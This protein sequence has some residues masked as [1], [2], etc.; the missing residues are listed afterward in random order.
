M[1]ILHFSGY[2]L[3]KLFQKPATKMYP[4]RKREFFERT[5]G[6]IG[7]D[8]DAC[9]FCGMCGRKCPTGAIGVDRN[10]KT[11]D[12]ERLQCIQCSCCVEVCP[13]KCLTMENAYTAPSEGSVKDVFHARVP[14]NQPN[15]T[16][17]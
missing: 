1:A 4:I 17:S 7:I 5:R 11:W 2:V 13:K 16:D 6:H 3:K 10:S 8:I 14:D 15:H 12:I 9:I